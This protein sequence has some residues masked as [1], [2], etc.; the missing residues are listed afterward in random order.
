MYY[1]L[2]HQVNYYSKSSGTRPPLQTQSLRLR[3]WSQ[4]SSLRNTL[5]AIG[6]DALFDQMQ[7][8]RVP[9]PL[10]YFPEQNVMAHVVKVALKINVDDLGKPLH[11]P[12]HHSIQRLVRCPPGPVSKGTFVKISLKDRL[13]N[14]LYRSLNDSILDGGNS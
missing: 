1:L 9:Y 14:K 5:L 13:Q 2:C 4:H 11:Q 3:G 8:L 6:L 10:S 12:V 7:Y